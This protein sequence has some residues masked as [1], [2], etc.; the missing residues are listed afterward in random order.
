ME[1]SN[2]QVHEH[3]DALSSFLSCQSYIVYARSHTAGCHD[4]RFTISTPEQSYSVKRQYTTMTIRLRPTLSRLA[5]LRSGW[6]CSSC[7]SF[8]QHASKLS[9]RRRYSTP[10]TN[11]PEIFD[12]VIVG[13]GPAGL[14]LATALKSSS[15]TRNLKVAL[16]EGQS[17]LSSKEWLP[18]TGEFSNRVSSLTPKSVQFMQSTCVC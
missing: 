14:T 6:I 8:P 13:G 18:K 12:V 17:L 10:T 4:V 3:Q 2:K 1:G 15:I 11:S 9:D 16:I 7:S 5:P